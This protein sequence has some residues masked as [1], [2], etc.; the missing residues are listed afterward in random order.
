MN[1][2]HAVLAD[3]LTQRELGVNGESL[4][5][6]LRHPLNTCKNCNNSIN[7]I[8]SNKCKVLKNKKIQEIKNK[9]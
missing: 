8:G 4:C 2:Q 5:D 7:V 9:T 1:W 6:I 3:V